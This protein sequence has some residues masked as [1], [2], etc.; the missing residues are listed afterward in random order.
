MRLRSLRAEDVPR[1]VAVEAAA[2]ARYAAHGGPLAWVAG[3]PAIAPERFAVGET[4]VA[5]TADGAICG[6]ALSQPLDGHFYLANIA[7]APDAGGRGI[8]RALV[9]ETERR[10]GE[11]RLPGVALATFRDP[12]WNGPWFRRLGYGP[13]APERI[14]PGLRAI[15]DR[16]A[17][18]LDAATRETLWKPLAKEDAR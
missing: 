6:Y 15:L 5:E 8:G 2:R 4:V 7:V 3:A 11:L 14:G 13:I 10:A 17:S 1:L 12:P 18:Y 9:A 16:H